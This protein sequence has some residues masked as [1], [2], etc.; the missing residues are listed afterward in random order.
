MRYVSYVTDRGS[1]APAIAALAVVIVFA[2]AVQTKSENKPSQSA[3]C[4]MLGSAA[5][6]NNLPVEFLTRVIW[7]ESRFDPQAIGP[8]TRHGTRAEGI[9]QFMPGTAAERALEDPLDPVQALPK[10]AAFVRE[11]R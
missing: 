5:T 2:F 1:S 6:A 10:E 8:L 7:R 4:L 11:P 3:M 9:A